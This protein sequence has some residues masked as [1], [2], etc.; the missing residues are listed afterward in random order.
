M[1]KSKKDNPTRAALLQAGNIR[2]SEYNVQESGAQIGRTYSKQ[3]SQALAIAARRN[4][5]RKTVKV[6][7][8]K[9]QG[10]SN[11]N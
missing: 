5:F 1:A 8:Q 4:E 2:R 10:T 3:D 11:G 6:Q 7:Q 9:Q